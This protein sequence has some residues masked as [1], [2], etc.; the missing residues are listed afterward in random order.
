MG[1][2]RRLSF[3]CISAF[4]LESKETQVEVQVGVLWSVV[5]RP[6]TIIR[7]KSNYLELLA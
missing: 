5:S 1:K 3:G 6:S 7:S 4:L 2:I